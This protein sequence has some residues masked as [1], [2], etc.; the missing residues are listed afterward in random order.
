MAF[1]ML[2][3]GF[4]FAGA[5]KVVS[6]VFPEHSGYVEEVNRHNLALERFNADKEAY[7]RELTELRLK[8]HNRD[9]NQMKSEQ[10]HNKSLEN[11]D[12]YSNSRLNKLIK[13]G[14]PKLED[15]I[16]SINSDMKKDRL[17]GTFTNGDIVKL[18]LI[19]GGIIGGTYVYKHY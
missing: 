16:G 3:A 9:R 2:L 12:N 15:Y 11:I 1:S 8:E 6:K 14:P 7:N 5:S 10:T 13:S 17:F 18:S 19:T 4:A